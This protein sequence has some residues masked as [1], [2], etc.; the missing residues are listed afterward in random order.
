L[1]INYDYFYS[2]IAGYAANGA[3]IHYK[4]EKMTASKIG[5]NGTFLLDSGGQYLDGTTDVTRCSD[6]SFLEYYAF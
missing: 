2:T 6:E 1:L 4:P 5:L 3:I